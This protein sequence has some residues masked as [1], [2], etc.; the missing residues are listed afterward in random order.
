MPKHETTDVVVGSITFRGEAARHLK[1]CKREGGTRNLPE[2]KTCILTAIEF[3][4][5]LTRLSA[6]ENLTPL[7]PDTGAQETVR[8]LTSQESLLP[9]GHASNRVRGLRVPRETAEFLGIIAMEYDASLPQAIRSAVEFYYLLG[10]GQWR[11]TVT[12]ASN[13]GG[14]ET[15]EFQT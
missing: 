6:E 7:R 4:L 2:A 1:R 3:F 14:T 11:F 12:F 5:E 8:V 9:N 15:R 10:N 13:A